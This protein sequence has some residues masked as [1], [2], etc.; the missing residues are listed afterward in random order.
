[1][2]K[3]FFLTILIVL[4]ILISAE[5]F[6]RKI[7]LSKKIN[8]KEYVFYNDINGHPVIPY[9]I[10]IDSRVQVNNISIIPITSGK[11]DIEFKSNNSDYSLIGDKSFVESPSKHYSNIEIGY[12]G[13]STI[14]NVMY[15]PALLSDTISYSNGFTIDIDYTV[16]G[17]ASP[18]SVFD[19][20]LLDNDN[21]TIIYTTYKTAAN[22]TLDMILI[23]TNE[24]KN[25]FNE[26]IMLSDLM[27]IK[28][29]IETVENIEHNYIGSDTQEKIRNFI[30]E[31]YYTK[32]IRMVTICGD[33][34]IVPIRMA[35]NNN[36]MYYGYIPT[37]MYYGD[38]DGNWNADND[39]II[40]ELQE[41][42]IDG[43][44]ELSISRLPFENENELN[45]LLN[46]IQSYIF[47]NNENNLDKFLLLG[48]SI[49]S[50]LTDGTGQRY[51]DQVS[52][53]ETTNSYSFNKLYSPIQDTFRDYPSWL[54]GD[55]Q[56]NAS[57]F[58]NETN[59]GYY[60]IN[61]IDHSNEYWMGMGM[62]ETQTEFF[63]SDINSLN[64][65]SNTYSILFSMGCSPNAFDRESISEILINASNSS[66]VSYT[67]FTRTGWTSSR[68]WM[69]TFWNT[70]A[71]NDTKY[72]Y[73]AFLSAMENYYLY[74]RLTINN[75]GIP[76]LPIYHKQFKPLI[77][78]TPD[79]INRGDEITISVTDGIYNLENATIVLMDSKNYYR[80]NTDL[81]GRAIFKYNFSDSI[82]LIGVSRESSIPVFDTIYISGNNPISIDSLIISQS[83]DSLL[84]NITNNSDTSINDI[85]VIISKNDSLLNINETIVIDCLDAN[86]SIELQCNINSF[87]SPIYSCYKNVFINTFFNDKSYND[88][89]PVLI[90]K[91][92]LGIKGFSSHTNGNRIFIDTIRIYNN[93]NNNLLNTIINI[94]SED[95]SI[96][97][98]LYNQDI[99]MFDTIFI[100]NIACSNIITDYENVVF[101]I[102]LTANN[103]TKE[104]TVK[105]VNDSL[106]DFNF[107]Y[108]INGIKLSHNGNNV[109]AYIYCSDNDYSSF[110]LLDSILPGTQ[111]I[112]DNSIKNHTQ[113]YYAEF[114]DNIGRTLCISDTIE[115]NSYF[116]IYKSST[117][118]SGSYYGKLNDKRFYAKSSMNLAD[119]NNNGTDEI[120]IIAEDGKIFIFDDDLNDITPFDIRVGKLNET[121]PAIGDIDKNGYLDIVFGGGYNN[122]TTA[123]IILNP[124]LDNYECEYILN[125]GTL[126]TSPVLSDINSDG[127]LE[128]LLGTTTGFYVYN[129][130]FDEISE[131]RKL[132]SNIT[133]IAVSP[134]RNIIAFSN[135]Y[136]TIFAMDNTGN[137]L[138]GFPYNT[139]EVI[140]APFIMGD[141]DNNS[142]I[143]IVVAT[144]MGNLFVINE[145]GV[146]RNNF[147][148]SDINP[149]Y[150][151]PRITDYNRDG[152][153]E[154]SVFDLNGN[155]TIIDNNGNLISNYSIDETGNN[156]YNEP[157][158]GDFDSNGDNEIIL[159]T[160]NGNIHIIDFSGNLMKD[161]FSVNN[162]ITSTPILLTSDKG[163][164][165]II[166]D[167]SGNIYKLEYMESSFKSAA[168]VIFKKTLFDIANTSYVDVH[169]LSRIKK[170]NMPVPVIE[171]PEFVR[172]SSSIIKNQLNINYSINNNEKI[173]ILVI[174]KLGSIVYESFLENKYNNKVIDFNNLHFSS[175]EYFL[176]YKLNKKQEYRK[177][178]YLK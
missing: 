9:K 77:V 31:T 126:N 164:S 117:I 3:I 69:T 178:V 148:Y 24:F 93:S 157:L 137:S 20:Q 81:S 22:A 142:D 74:F 34:N 124:F 140:L 110:Y 55:N 151:S 87:K 43:Y 26:L 125:K 4:S 171:M 57:N 139:G 51:C 144:A 128:I 167:L 7:D 163:I 168:S 85:S 169:L 30:K 86:E 138:S 60:F 80:K 14:V 105:T 127:L 112:F 37:D 46:K 90:E 98:S 107:T 119:M 84:I 79:T 12:M 66:I 154:I 1:M 156:T 143:D 96:N 75:L 170:N 65:Y 134:E 160:C 135:Y 166:K 10:I 52:G 147:P 130:N 149:V 82:I 27:G 11:T 58:I 73:E 44:P 136:G 104:Y 70:L 54:M 91:D 109:F 50:G 145:Y 89:I 16:Q 133:A 159:S 47:N 83:C 32:G 15:F 176:A 53:L 100:T 152:Q 6:A 39:A 13:N 175:G 101:N 115:I 111:Y 161:I 25:A 131:M 116:N 121:T 97:D 71:D 102:S 49:T 63:T 61:H 158:I 36:Y 56:L 95:C 132:Y 155:F 162:A 38:M 67:G 45:I 62:Y 68:T 29:D 21:Q 5:K 76:S 8:D 35:Y 33:A 172:L 72:F 174:N 92:N 113:F 114:F 17:N 122:D 23:T 173:K 42:N 19:K 28:T 103:R 48:S 146:L 123:L 120:V 106:I 150:Q 177:F 99:S 88:S 18:L 40:G 2:K 141:I 153:C 41:D 64:N 78:I 118:I 129:C 108:D 94:S 165:L 59:N